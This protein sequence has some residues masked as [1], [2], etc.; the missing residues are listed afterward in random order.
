MYLGSKKTVLILPILMVVLVLLNIPIAAGATAID[1]QEEIKRLQEE[2]ANN[3][4]SL[5]K[6]TLSYQQTLSGTL[7]CRT[8]KGFSRLQYRVVFLE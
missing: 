7:T 8:R 1:K 3:R 5:D 2:I 6:A 4:A